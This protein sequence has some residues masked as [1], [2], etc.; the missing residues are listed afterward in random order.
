MKRAILTG[1]TS[2]IGEVIARRLA[3]QNVTLVLIG[4]SDDRL[5]TARRRI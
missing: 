2:R 3:T 4:R 1:A 5:A